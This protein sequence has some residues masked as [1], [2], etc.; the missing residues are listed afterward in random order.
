MYYDVYIDIVFGMNLLMDYIL[1][2]IVEKA[3]SAQMQPEKNISLCCSR[4]A[5]FLPCSLYT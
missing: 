5:V 3:V 1:L 4:S 2:R